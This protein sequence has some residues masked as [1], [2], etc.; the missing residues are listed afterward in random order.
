MG[1]LYFSTKFEFD[2]S[3]NNG[4]LLSDRNNWKH[5]QTD[6][7]TL[8]IYHIGSSNSLIKREPWPSGTALT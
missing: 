4:D 3:T 7:D 6:T 2:Q 1:I 5:R 8:P